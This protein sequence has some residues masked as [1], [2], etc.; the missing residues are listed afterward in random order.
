MMAGMIAQPG[1]DAVHAILHG[2]IRAGHMQRE[3]EA[4]AVTTEELPHDLP[5]GARRRGVALLRSGI[6]V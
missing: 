4:I 2:R 6:A 1:V 3:L 5:I